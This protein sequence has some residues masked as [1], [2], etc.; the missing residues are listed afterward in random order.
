VAAMTHT[1]VMDEWPLDDDRRVV[2]ALIL[3]QGRWRVEGRIWFRADDGSIRPG[4]GLALGVKH[5]ER[6]AAAIEKTRRG[7][8][9]RDLIPPPRGEDDR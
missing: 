9:A 3:F 6:L 5:L 8:V 1:A 7:A 2:I 4:R